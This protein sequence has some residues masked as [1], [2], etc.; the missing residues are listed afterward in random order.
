[1]N[2]WVCLFFYLFIFSWR[3]NAL[4]YCIGFCQTPIWISHRYVHVPSLLSLPLTCLSIPPLLKLKCKVDIIMVSLS[5]KEKKII[6]I[7]THT[8]I[9]MNAVPYHLQEQ[10][11]KVSLSILSIFLITVK[12]RTEAKDVSVPLW[13]VPEQTFVNLRTYLSQELQ[14]YQLIP[15]H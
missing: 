1:M 10:N 9:F 5:W 8:Y 6:Y 14:C 15:Q 13:F 4:L 7:Y 12:A 3:I 11:F 2:F